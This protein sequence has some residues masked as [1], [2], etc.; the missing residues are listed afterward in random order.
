MSDD[1]EP[2][3]DLWTAKER[4]KLAEQDRDRLARLEKTLAEH[5]AKLEATLTEQAVPEASGVRIGG[6]LCVPPPLT[7]EEEVGA[8]LMY[9]S[10]VL[11]AVCEGWAPTMETR[12]LRDE[13]LKK[14]MSYMV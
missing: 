14:V 6:T 10:H 3:R 5:Q 12:R 2:I 1:A 4:A 13:L 8:K 7:K 11:R 9:L